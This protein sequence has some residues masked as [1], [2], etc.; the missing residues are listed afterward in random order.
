MSPAAQAKQEVRR[1]RAE[2]R[3]RKIAEGWQFLDELHIPGRLPL[4]PG[5]R[6]QIKGRRGWW[7]FT[8][9]CVTPDG[10]THINCAGPYRKSEVGSSASNTFVL[11]DELGPVEV[12]GKLNPD[13]VYNC[14]IRVEVTRVERDVGPAVK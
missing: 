3:A 7:K 6:F 9:A 8:G 5:R 2:S 4:V 11:M 10:R 14:D 1:R 12:R 13:Y